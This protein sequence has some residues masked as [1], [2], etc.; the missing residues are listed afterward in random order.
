MTKPSDDPRCAFNWRH[1]DY[2]HDIDWKE[3]NK[4]A[5]Y[6]KSQAKVVN[7]KRKQGKELSIN[8]PYSEKSKHMI[9]DPY[10][11]KIK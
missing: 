2:K 1:P 6:S 11:F 7:D 10:H 4:S 9:G 8:L 5:M 3:L